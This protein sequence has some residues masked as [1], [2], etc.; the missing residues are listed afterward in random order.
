MICSFR[1]EGI[2]VTLLRRTHGYVT[3]K[4]QSCYAHKRGM[5][6]ASLFLLSKQLKNKERKLSKEDFCQPYIASESRKECSSS[7]FSVEVTT[8]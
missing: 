2:P 4:M 7:G 1:N 6:W 3:T 5:L 8:D